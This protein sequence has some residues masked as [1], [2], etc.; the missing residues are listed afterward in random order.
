M[1]STATPFQGLSFPERVPTNELWGSLPLTRVQRSPLSAAE[2]PQVCRKLCLTALL[3]SPWLSAQEPYSLEVHT[4]FPAEVSYQK[5]PQSAF[6]I[7][8]PESARPDHYPLPPETYG[9]TITLKALDQRPLFYQRI[10][11]QK[12]H[13]NSSTAPIQLVL[14]RTW[15]WER[16]LILG[17]LPILGSF[18]LFAKSRQRQFEEKLLQQEPLIRSDGKIPQR[19]VA[20]YQLLSIL[21]SGA[22]GV[23][24]LGQNQGGEK[25]AIKV[26]LPNLSADNDFTA[27]FSRELQVCLGLQH[28]RIVRLLGISSENEAYMLMEYVEGQ[29][30]D[31]LERLP[32]ADEL[33]RCWDWAEQILQALD[34]IHSRGIIHRDLK[35]A[36]LMVDSKGNIKLMDFGV[37]HTPDRTRLTATGTV[38]GTP[39]YKA[40]EQIQGAPCTPSIDLYALGLILY[41]RLA[42]KNPFSEDFMMLLQEK[43]SGPLQAIRHW[44]PQVPQAWQ[45]FLETLCHSQPQQRPHAREALQALQKLPRALLMTN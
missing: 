22:M 43:L 35:P 11:T 21:G 6:Q 12:V 14:E 7:L 28:P 18:V 31:K 36:N 16:I 2:T 15:R 3:F 19:Q 29:T 27:R 24:Y 30:L 10:A 25:C 5:D 40:P 4:N 45:D 33:Q 44:E 41:E 37:A 8:S 23:V 20:G 17:F 1:A 26:P 9:S 13:I 38:L 42:G 34:Y 32:V 39:F